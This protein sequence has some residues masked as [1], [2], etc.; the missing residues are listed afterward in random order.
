MRR[1]LPAA[2]ALAMAVPAFAID[3]HDVTYTEGFPVTREKG[4]YEA[5]INI[6][7]RL[8]AGQ[9]VVTRTGDLV[10]MKAGGYTVKV[11]ENT[12]FT[13][14]E[15]EQGGQSQPVL[16]NVLGKIRFARDRATGSDPRLITNSIVCGVRGTVV[17]LFAGEDG[18][19]LVIVDEGLVQIT[20]SGGA[21]ELAKGEGVEVRTD[22]TT[23]EKFRALSTTVDYGSWNGERLQ[24][25]LADP[26]GAARRIEQR[27]DSYIEQI[28]AIEPLYN[29][30]RA[31]LDAVQKRRTE[32]AG[33]GQTA[34]LTDY[35]TNVYAPL[36]DET[37]FLVV[38][39]RYYALSALSLR[40]FVAGR[41]YLQV[42][43][44]LMADPA[45]A[46][47]R[48]FLAIHGRV[49]EKFEQA[50]TGHLVPADI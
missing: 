49:L 46:D 10:E 31:E 47:A 48:E 23:G 45:T 38:N 44:R 32:L 6:G 9:T 8:I 29:A 36:R 30:K 14:M 41:L 35:T 22:G 39:L 2:L 34:E 43:P 37:R 24:S 19:S 18:S 1:L 11:D 20:S 3:Q 50:V 26:A 4:R 27:L 40:R 16:A 17:T 13:I 21:V 25:M 15:V 5:D 33:K 12:V 42:K 7:D 28:R